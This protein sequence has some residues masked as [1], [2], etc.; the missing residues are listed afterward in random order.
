[1]KSNRVG[2]NTVTRLNLKYVL[3]HLI[4]SSE[5]KLYF[6]VGRVIELKYPRGGNKDTPVYLGTVIGDISL[7]R[8]DS[9]VIGAKITQLFY[10]LKQE[11]EIVASYS[12]DFE[13]A[14][15]RLVLSGFES[16]LISLSF[17][18]YHSLKVFTDEL[19]I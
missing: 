18:H 6:L 13:Y 12:K 3:V 15:E 10:F 11:P 9:T 19:S 8:T 17:A 5:E 7:N 14:A 2:K 16:S 1:M 4:K